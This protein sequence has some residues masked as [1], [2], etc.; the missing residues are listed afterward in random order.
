MLINSICE[1]DIEIGVNADNWEDVI[2]K[3][4]KILLEKK[5]IEAGYVEAMIDAVKKNGPYI[6]IS[7]HIA[8]AHAR[9]EYGVNKLGLS[10]A[11]LARPVN[12]G[13]GKLDPVKLVITLAAPDQNAHIEL[14]AQLAE[15]LVDEDRVEALV[16]ATSSEEFCRILR[17][18]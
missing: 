10:F 7:K 16:K 18:G 9:P 3:C 8:L 13:A 11:T 1:N 5:S 12:F 6:V 17:S 15:I 2:R 4:A 14:M